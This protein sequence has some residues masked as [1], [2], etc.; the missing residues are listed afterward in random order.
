[1]KFYPLTTIQ[2]DDLMQIKYSFYP[3]SGQLA[4]YVTLGEEIDPEIMKKAVNTEIERNDCL[5]L[6]FTT[7]GFKT[8][9]YF[10]PEYK[11]ENIPFDDFRGKA[12]I[13]MINHLKSDAGIPLKY[14]KGE[15]FRIRFF[16]APDGRFG[17]YLCIMHL[18]MDISAILHFFRDLIC[19]YYSLK[20]GSELPAPLSAF[21]DGIKRDLDIF[22]N[23][24]RMERNNKFFDE[25]LRE[26]GPDF[27]A[28]VDG[29][30]ELKKLRKRF[31]NRKI[32]YS[33]AYDLFH[34]QSDTLCFHLDGDLFE[35]M[36]A[37][38]KEKRVP[39]QSLLQ[40]G[41]RTHLSKINEY[42]D[43][44]NLMVLINRR[45]TIADMNSGGSRAL[46]LPVRTVISKDSTFTE[47]LSQQ[48][49]CQMKVF[50]HC[51]YSSKKCAL[52]SSKIN[53]RMFGALTTSM[54]FTYLPK[55]FLNLP[56]GIDCRFG[57][58]S[59]G[60]FVCILYTMVVPSFDD[61][62]LD[63]YYEYQ[64]YKLNPQD[65]ESMHKNMT[66]VIEAG[67]E[68]PDITIGDILENVL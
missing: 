43:D 35:K 42:S 4:F 54:L 22:S 48:S 53:H 17:V 9:Q 37:F 51:D 10:L 55:E 65:L 49:I 63:F 13:D 67:I 1:M 12:E 30:R 8:Y 44:V 11:I 33:I 27:Y 58:I 47:A 6:R 60:H 68:N 19:V 3:Q 41:I 18:S 25:Y 45:A 57:G 29:M 20:N 64:T 39:L 40:L 23:K 61:G 5:R 38:C 14:K 34:D 2:D 21:E 26:N 36:D 59:T 16:A 66:K 56:E 62:G 7:K 52:E 46:G 28:G 50:K 15:T 31:L 24:Q 32:N